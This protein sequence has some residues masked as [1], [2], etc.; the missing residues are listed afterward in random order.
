MIFQIDKAKQLEYQFFISICSFGAIS[1]IILFFF[2]LLYTQNYYSVAIESLAFFL[3]VF[4]NRKAR[5]WQEI[6]WLG[7]LLIPALYIMI[8]VALVIDG[9]GFNFA[10]SIIF[11]LIFIISLIIVGARDRNVLIIVT[12]INLMLLLIIQRYFPAYWI[13][14]EP[15]GSEPSYAYAFK[16]ALFVVGGYLVVFLKS[17]YEKL[18][19]EL[20]KI[21]EEI[22]QNNLYLELKVEERTEE[23]QK[24]NRELDLLFYRSSHDFRRP[25]TTLKGLNEVAR[26]TRIDS[27]GMELMH[28]MVNTVNL[29]DMMLK[30]FYMLYEISSFQHNGYKIS[31]NQIMYD[32]K[33]S[34][35]KK[36]HRIDFQINLIHYKDLDSR[37]RIVSIILENL[38]ENA[39]HYAKGNMADIK[40]NIVEYDRSIEIHF[41]DRGI[42]IDENYFNRIFEMYFRGTE[43]SKGNG[44]GLYVVKC[45]VEKLNGTIQLESKKEDFTRFDIYFPI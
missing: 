31:L 5:E 33:D 23:L 39:I 26:L 12:S 16:I 15:S 34:V 10:N 3:F 32:M 35:Q 1:T 40:V 13:I 44:L 45:G 24:L 7:K 37:N 41:E 11:F 25:L 28:L 2:D 8:N 14:R 6:R 38:V 20:L 36:G 19:E 21:N 17:K 9:G 30:K 43:L 27:E 22:I 18:S 29:M 4:V 42:G